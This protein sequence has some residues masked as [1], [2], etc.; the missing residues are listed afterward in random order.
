MTDAERQWLRNRPYHAEEGVV[1]D[2]IDY[3]DSV[4]ECRQWCSSTDPAPGPATASG[5]FV[6]R[7]GQTARLPSTVAPQPAIPR[8]R[9]PEF[10]VNL[11]T[12]PSKVLKNWPESDSPKFTGGTGESAQDWLRTIEVLLDDRQAH[13]GIWHRC[14]GQRLS[15]KPFEIGPMLDWP[16]LDPLVGK[17]FRSGLSG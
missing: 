16:G 7:P 17:T 4:D 14:A 2:L 1:L 8:G 12:D 13:R 6:P 5:S 10:P 3:E 15:K 9:V 11:V